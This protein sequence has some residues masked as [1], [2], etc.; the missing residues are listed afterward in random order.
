[1]W[2]GLW[3]AARMMRKSPGFTAVAV[4][5][6]AHAGIIMMDGAVDDR[7]PVT[8]PD[9]IAAF[10]DRHDVRVPRA[11]KDQVF[12][13]VRLRLSLYHRHGED[14]GEFKARKHRVSEIKLVRHGD[15][16]HYPRS[17]QDHKV[18]KN[19]F[20]V[21]VPGCR[22]LDRLICSRYFC[23]YKNWISQLNRTVKK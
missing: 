8:T 2:H 10:R 17:F 19:N 11:D 5:T 23:F 14:N 21:S 12:A 3:Y 6:L 13:H 9:I 20:R 4:L 22:T 7:Y 15:N 18:Y 1:M 16:I